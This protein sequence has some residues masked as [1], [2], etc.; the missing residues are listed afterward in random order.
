[1]G[2]DAGENSES[3]L[4]LLPESFNFF[5][6]WTLA[7]QRNNLK[8]NYNLTV[9]AGGKFFVSKNLTQMPLYGIPHIRNG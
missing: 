9:G 6:G 3:K 5:C 4:Q 1:M 8:A 7:C 2:K